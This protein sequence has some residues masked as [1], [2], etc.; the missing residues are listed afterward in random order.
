MKKNLLFFG[1]IICIHITALL[2]FGL[3]RGVLLLNHLEQTVEIADRTSMIL[4]AFWMGFR[5]DTVISCYVLIAPVVIGMF[6]SLFQF[7]P[8][9][10]FK[11]IFIYCCV[12]FSVTLLVCAANIPYFNVFFKNINASIWNWIDEPAFVAEMIVKESRFWI[13]FIVYLIVNFAFCFALYKVYRYF[14]NKV[15]NI[16]QRFNYR[17]S[18]YSFFIGILLLGVCFI[19]GRGRIELK[20]PIR[21]G[22]AYFSNNVFLNQLGLN[23]NFVL[24]NTSLEQINGKSKEVKLMD[25]SEAI[26]NVR[27]YLNITSDDPDSPIARMIPAADSVQRKNVVLILMESMTSYYLYSDSTDTKV[28]FLKDLLTKSVHFP[29]F[30]SAGVHTFNGIYSSLF[31]YPALLSQHS[32]KSGDMLSYAGMPAVLRNHGY[33]TI[34]FS[35]HDAQFDNVGGFL[36]ANQVEQIISQKD[37]PGKE[38]LSNLGV[39]DDYMFR[40]SMDYLNNAPEP[41][42]ATFLTAS[43]HPPYIIPSYFTPRSDK[44]KEQ[45]VEY[46]DWAVQQFFELAEKEKWYENTIFVITGDH[47]ASVG[48][49]DALF[50]YHQVPFIVYEPEKNEAK[51]VDHLGGQIDIFPTIM[52]VLGL[53][54]HNNTFGID[55]LNEQRPYMF[56]S[57]DDAFECIDHEWYYVHRTGGDESLYRHVDKNGV[58]VIDSYPEIAAEMKKYATSMLQATQYVIKEGLVR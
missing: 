47:G 52:G 43:N 37:Y 39:P 12:V 40:F 46:S 54:Y 29:N 26:R 9:A 23:P 4:Q 25:N 32:M 7:Y 28:P 55:I 38:V 48:G 27:E 58:D 14:W 15:K 3:F 42:F 36:M 51:M 56:F 22:T 45:I 17:F 35:T 24:L 53:E 34:Y 21:V 31:S 20:S 50:S 49:Y 11:G 18:L 57:S 6:F 41:F 10:L 30:Y 8:K 1:H 13:Y 5:F 44:I 16:E 33:R 19:G 2:F